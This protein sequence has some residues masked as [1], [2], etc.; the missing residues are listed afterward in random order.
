MRKFPNLE[1]YECTV[2]LLDECYTLR[3]PK[4][5]EK[6]I[7]EE[8]FETVG[9]FSAFL[10]VFPRHWS[11]YNKVKK[12]REN[13]SFQLP[14]T[15]NVMLGSHKTPHHALEES[16]QIDGLINIS[17]QKLQRLGNH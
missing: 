10:S 8:S 7:F 14:T 4:F 5:L 17:R 15:E 6:A 13:S 11:V 2:H 12:A 1:L 16:K 9:H 3:E